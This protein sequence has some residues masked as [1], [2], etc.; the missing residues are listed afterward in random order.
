MLSDQQSNSFPPKPSGFQGL[1]SSGRLVV[2]NSEGKTEESFDFLEQ[3][4]AMLEVA[5]QPAAVRG[6]WLVLDGS[7][8]YVRP[9]L[10]EVGP[11]D[12]GGVRSSTVIAA[13][14]PDHIPD[15]V[16]EFQHSLG[17]SLQASSMT[18]FENWLALDLPP[19]LAAV[20]G[21]SGLNEMI[22]EFPQPAPLRRRIVLGDVLQRAAHPAE[23]PEAHPF[24][25]CC[26]LTNCLEAFSEEISRDAF[27][28]IRLLAARDQD[29]QV[30]ADCRINGLDYPSGHAALLDYARTWP[31]RGFEMRKQYVVVHTLD[32]VILQ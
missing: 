31:D 7:G 3:L 21:T 24:C 17:E 30:S 15:G 23:G 10:F 6:D 8:L 26:L 20:E 29:G 16:F 27:L 14:H 18:G 1:G 22:M 28:G 5:G 2:E 32:S 12:G 19:L 13:A 4:R 11:Q 25:P 9:E